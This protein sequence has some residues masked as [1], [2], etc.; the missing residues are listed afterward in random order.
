LC[1]GPDAARRLH[2]QRICNPAA[3]VPA[4]TP[5]IEAAFPERFVRDAAGNLVS[6]EP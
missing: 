2:Q 6:T 5:E 1:N 4:A 3:S